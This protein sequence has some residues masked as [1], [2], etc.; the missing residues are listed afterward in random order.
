MTKDDRQLVHFV[1][2]VE[3]WQERPVEAPSEVSFARLL[4]PGD[5]TTLQ[6][7]L[8]KPNR[9][10]LVTKKA[11]GSDFTWT[12]PI[13]NDGMI[14]CGGSNVVGL[15]FGEERT[16]RL[17]VLLDGLP[18]KDAAIP[19]KMKTPLSIAYSAEYDLLACGAREGQ[20]WA[21]GPDGAWREV[22]NLPTEAP[23]LD[24]ALNRS[25]DIA[26]VAARKVYI[27]DMTTGR[28]LLVLG[29]DFDAEF[30]VDLAWNE[31]QQELCVATTTRVLRWSVAPD[32]DSR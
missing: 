26:F 5:S 10:Q 29:E 2:T 25:G 7:Q 27:V 18:V 16:E 14:Y 13:P 19:K 32:W 20:V 8:M 11:G 17:Q 15:L 12:K 22:V 1:S 6:V 9:Y 31:K 30:V 23:V 21:L 3:G 28:I 4:Q 24:L